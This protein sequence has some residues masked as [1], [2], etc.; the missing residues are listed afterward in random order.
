M[1]LPVG[2]ADTLHFAAADAG[3]LPLECRPVSVA[4]LV[5]T[6]LAR[7]APLA[8]T[9]GVNL[10]D[11]V[12]RG[13]PLLDL[14]SAR[15]GQALFNLLE[16]AIRHTPTGGVVR[17]Q[18]WP[19]TV[20]WAGPDDGLRRRSPGVHLTIRDNGEGISPEHLPHLF[21]RFYSV[22]RARSRAD[23]GSGLGLAIVRA[24]VEAH[25]GQVRVDSDGVPGHGSTFTIRLPVKPLANL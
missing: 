5:Q 13:L 12:P 22:D 17:V 18:A 14:D 2:G 9:K 25:G 11:E 7:V 6:A 21:E 20:T 23:G 15:I 10:V 19:G 24:I 8:A 3:A 4:A 16:N 1:P